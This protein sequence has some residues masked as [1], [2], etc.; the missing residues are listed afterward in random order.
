[1]EI[2]DGPVLVVA[3]AGTGKTRVI[4]ERVM[5]LLSKGVAPEAILALT[6]T[7]KAAGEM[8][9]RLNQIRGGITLDA[10]I[11]TY[12]GFGND[13]LEHYGAEW[14]LGT[15][16]LL[17]ET[18]KL[19]FLREHLDEFKL[20]YFAPISQPDSQLALLAD[21]ASLLKQQLVQ[22]ETYL[23]YA[24]KLSDNTETEQLD[25]RRHLELASFYD[26]YIKLCRTH[27]VIDYDDQLYATIGL[28]K[29]RPNPTCF[30]DPL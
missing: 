24:R 18:G 25:R 21:Y 8:L 16:R 7:E 17:G 30:A 4:V 29:D 14:G 13:L 1:M 6:F 27:Q 2:T 12:N 22:P 28:L 3:G 20:D 19:V 11:A 26:T 5:H 9:D 10:T 23:A 15:L